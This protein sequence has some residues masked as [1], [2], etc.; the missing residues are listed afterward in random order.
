METSTCCCGDTKAIIS[1]RAAEH[2]INNSE[3]RV[4]N[5]KKAGR[6][7]VPLLFGSSVPRVQNAEAHFSVVVEVWVEAHRAVA[8]CLQ[9]HLR[10][11]VWIVLW[12][13]YVELKTTVSVRRVRWT[14]YEHLLVKIT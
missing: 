8:C 12:K 1:L 5:L 7:S 6:L 11:R 13:I 4:G 2:K 9:V 14:R 3:C 10:R